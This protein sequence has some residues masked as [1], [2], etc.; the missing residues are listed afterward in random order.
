MKKLPE[1]MTLRLRKCLWK[2][3]RNPVQRHFLER[4]TGTLYAWFPWG[5]F[6][7]NFAGEP[8]SVNPEAFKDLRFFLNRELLPG[9]EE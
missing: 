8:M 1:G 5:I 4:S 7:L 3:Q 6:P 9:L 2:R